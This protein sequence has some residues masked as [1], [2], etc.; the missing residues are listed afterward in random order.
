MTADHGVDVSHA[1]LR[2][3]GTGLSGTGTSQ[4]E[5]V[6]ALR[7]YLE[8]EGDPWGEDMMGSMVGA[9]YH[10][11]TRHALEVYESLAERH[12]TTGDGAEFMAVSYRSAE[13]R[14]EE[15]VDRITRAV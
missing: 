15:E 3:T 13:Q 2:S 10:A 1:D 7:A 11:V 5:E 9:A 12:V 8:G 14:S 4:L 6:R